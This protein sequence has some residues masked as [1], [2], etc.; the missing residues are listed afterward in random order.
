MDFFKKTLGG[1]RDLTKYLQNIL[2]T[3][4]DGII[5]LVTFIPTLCTTWAIRYFLLTIILMGVIKVDVIY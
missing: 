2:Q 4:W 1:V 5:C 3:I